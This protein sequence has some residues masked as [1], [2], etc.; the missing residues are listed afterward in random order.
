MSNEKII[1]GIV[2]FNKEQELVRC[3]RA[4][5]AQT[6]KVQ[7]ILIVDN[8]SKLL[9]ENYL[10]AEFNLVRERIHYRKLSEN[11]G[12]A[13]GFSTAMD[14]A[15][16]RDAD[17]V[18]LMD[19]DGYPSQ[20]CLENLSRDQK[21]IG[22]IIGPVVLDIEGSGDLSFDYQDRLGKQYRICLQ[23]E[24][25]IW[26]NNLFPFNGTLISS[27]IVEKIGNVKK[28]MFIWGDEREY[29]FRARKNGIRVNTSL[30]A[31]FFHP[32]SKSTYI[33][34]FR[35]QQ[36]E[37]KNSKLEYNFYRNLGYIARA[38]PR[39]PPFATIAH[40]FVAFLRR[41]QIRKFLKFCLYFFDG[42]FDL[43]K[44]RN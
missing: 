14:W 20:N 29:V 30:R 13:G 39:V 27:S 8:N 42:Y 21:E 43:Y 40:Y 5:L 16:Q 11:T 2:T 6:R 4:I 34:S 41:G 3:I 23:A 1:A 9:S 12:G 37:V 19:D 35:G 18:W 31:E 44:L 17:F 28:E 36:V 22:G 33:A 15:M 38:Y 24:K 26:D 7:E 32:K 10:R 25:N